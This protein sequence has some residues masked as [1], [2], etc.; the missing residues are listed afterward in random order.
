MGGEVTRINALVQ[1]LLD[2]ARPAPPKLAAVDLTALLDQTLD[3]LSHELGQKRITVQRNDARPTVV[4]ADS[5]QL[6]QVLLNLLL[7]SLHAMESAGG[8]LTLTTRRQDQLLELTI[9]DTGCGIRPEHLARLGEPFFTTKPRG[10]GLGLAV[11]QSIL[12]EHGGSLRITSAVGCGT[13]VWV[14]LPL[15]A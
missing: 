15:A 1:Q 3:S 2:F 10:T 8:T 7:N 4:R 6:T 5:Q 13:T 11:V 14:M 12:Q 9:A